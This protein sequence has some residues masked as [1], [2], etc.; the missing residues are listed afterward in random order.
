VGR[1]LLSRV[2]SE[3]VASVIAPYYQ[4]DY[5]TI[6]HGDCLDEHMLE[7]WLS[8]DVLVT[9]PPYGI[10]YAGSEGG[11][12]NGWE[13]ARRFRDVAIYNDSDTD[14]RGAGVWHV[15]SAKATR[16]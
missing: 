13:S 16:H 10:S 3:W 4:D 12:R 11:P 8:G 2:L 7:A 9:D 15:E 6:Y 5:A 14:A 1:L